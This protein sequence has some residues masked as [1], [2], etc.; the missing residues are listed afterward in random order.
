MWKNLHKISF[1]FQIILIFFVT[2]AVMALFESVTRL[3]F[4][5][6]T[7]LQSL[8]TT[9]IFTFIVFLIIGYFPIRAAYRQ[10][11]MS[12]RE[13]DRRMAAESQL[14]QSEEKFQEIFD[15]VNDGIH[16]H[17][18]RP[19]GLPGKFIQVNTVACQMVHYS[20]EDLLA[21]SPLDLTTEYHSRPL[22]LIGE[23]LK[24][25]GHAIFETEHRRKDGTIVPVEVN[26]HVVIHH[27]KAVTISVVRD[28]TDRKKTERELQ[29]KEVFQQTLLD[30]LTAGV[31]IVDAETCTIEQVNPAAAAMFGTPVDQIIG[32][33]CHHFLCPADMGACPVTDL[34]QDVD[35]SERVML[36][37]DGTQIPILKSVKKIQLAGRTKLLEN[38]IDITTR[39]QAEE[40]LRESENRYRSVVENAT[41]A[42]IIAQ[43]GLLKYVNPRAVEMLQ[44]TTEQVLNQPFPR[45]I[46]PG[47]RALVVD[48]YQRRIRGET[49]P[50]HY[51]FRILGNDGMETWVQISA[52]FIQ[53]DGK[54]ATL[55]FLTDITNQK[56]IQEAL[57]ISNKKL[58]MLSSVTRHDILNQLMG[59]RTFLELSKEDTKDPT[60]LEYIAKEDQAAEAIQWQIEFARSYQELGTQAPQ[61]QNVADHINA[62]KQ[63]LDL[64]GIT[65]DVAVQSIEVFADAPFEKVFFN[66]MDNSLRHGGHVTRIEFSAAETEN[67]LVLS[68]RD[69]GVGIPQ[70]DKKKL[71]N[72]GFGKHIG[73]GL[74]LSSEILAVTNITI[75]ENGEPGKGVKFEITVPKGTYRFTTATKPELKNP[76]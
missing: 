60:L 45:F 54:P 74:F 27:G 49:V 14:Q 26:A 63:G 10:Q 44:S 38:F 6:F 52:V 67:G 35:Y 19:D 62:A 1:K 29:E 31:I 21:M 69:N 48:R 33:N 17:E 34:A 58:S 59:L 37:S 55:N 7:S 15:M 61:W 30:N 23:E 71:F 43:D 28:I 70:E 72:R 16:I 5:N 32:R 51:E 8:L 3:I 20:R 39:K 11:Q 22:S 40:A 4:Q 75:T 2:F 56:K 42:I 46:H 68:Y 76:A 73:L 65:V 24:T 57:V 66:L 41:E 13:Q 47:D 12:K 9:G 18:M 53:W 64:Q 36:R 25:T 50:S